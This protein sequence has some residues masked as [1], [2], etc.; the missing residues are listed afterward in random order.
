[1]LVAGVLLACFGGVL[2][3]GAFPAGRGSLVSLLVIG[4]SAIF[5]ASGAYLLNTVSRGEAR[6]RERG[7]PWRAERS[8]LGKTTRS[9]VTHVPPESALAAALD[10]LA[11]PSLGLIRVGN[12]PFGGVHAI[13]PAET[14]PIWISVVP[15]AIRVRARR[16]QDQTEISIS[17]VQS[18]LYG[19]P[20]LS[21]WVGWSSAYTWIEVAQD[22][23]DEI[24]NSLAARLNGRV[25]APSSGP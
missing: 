21:G 13:R 5:A 3:F 9:L 20:A 17:I 18:S 16:R 14:G 2:A 12:D 6:L 25:Q 11:Q 22:L 8:L 19:W 15:L 10:V 4:I 1:M 24:A 23:A 7:V